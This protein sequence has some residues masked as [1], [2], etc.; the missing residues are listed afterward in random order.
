[1]FFSSL[2]CITLRL[3]LIG[4]R[5]FIF[6]MGPP[7]IS[8][9]FSFFIKKVL[10]SVRDLEEVSIYHVRRIHNCLAHSLASRAVRQQTRV[11]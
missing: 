2:M 6:S 1:M 9:R 10:S 5:H 8:L 4:L 3:S 7:Q 11:F